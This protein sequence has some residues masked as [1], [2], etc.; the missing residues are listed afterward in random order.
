MLTLGVGVKRRERGGKKFREEQALPH[1]YNDAA[2]SVRGITKEYSRPKVGA[3]R[4]QSRES[5][6]PEKGR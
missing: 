4:L 5:R 2:A 3:N 1:K 6:D